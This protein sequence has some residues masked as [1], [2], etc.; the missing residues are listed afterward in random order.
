LMLRLQAYVEDE[1]NSYDAYMQA[2]DA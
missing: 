2:K 1:K